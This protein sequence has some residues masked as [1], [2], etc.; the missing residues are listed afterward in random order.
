MGGGI[1]CYKLFHITKK[2]QHPRFEDLPMSQNDQ[3]YYVNMPH[4]PIILN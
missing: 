3:H 4:S 2:C 1:Y